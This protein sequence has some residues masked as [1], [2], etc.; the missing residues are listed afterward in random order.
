M[1]SLFVINQT[2]SLLFHWM[3]YSALNIN[4]FSQRIDL[5]QDRR[6]A[7]FIVK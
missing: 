5:L 2:E 3:F 4:F 7:I 6:Y 1:E